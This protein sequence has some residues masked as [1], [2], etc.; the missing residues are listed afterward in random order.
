MEGTQLMGHCPKDR[1]DRFGIERRA[2]GRDPFECQIALIQGCFQ[3]P[4][5]RVDLV[6]A[7]IMIE[8]L[9]QNPFVLSIVD[10]RQDAIGAS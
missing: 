3:A 4:K 2:I 9:I 1:A 5:K 6:M 10:G 8:D 7:R